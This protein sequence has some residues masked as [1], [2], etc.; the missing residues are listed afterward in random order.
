M[1]RL[2]T[3]LITYWYSRYEWHSSILGV[4]FKSVADCDTD[5]CLVVAKFGERMPVSKE[6]AQT[7]DVGRYYL[8]KLSELEGCKQYQIQISKR[9]AALENLNDSEDINM[10]WENIKE[11]IKTSAKESLGLY[12]LKQ[13]KP[14]FDE[15]CSRFSDQRK[16]VKMERLHDPSQ[17]MHII[18]T[19]SDV[20]LVDISAT[21]RKNI[22]KLQFMNLKVTVRSKILRDLYRGK[23]WLMKCYQPG[24]NIVQYVMRRVI[25]LQTATVFWLGGGHI[26]FSYLMYIRLWIRKT[27]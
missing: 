23:K 22:W 14:L 1:G 5:H 20:K 13:H 16:Q 10:A 6:A 26:S 11:N 12:E 4:R 24:T 3:R 17:S 8:R 7:F 19:M 18:W 2:T 15:E 21:K 9:F 25:W 27:N